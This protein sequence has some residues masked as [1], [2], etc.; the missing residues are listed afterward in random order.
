MNSKRIDF[1]DFIDIG[2][3]NLRKIPNQFRG[4]SITPKFDKIKIPEFFLK[5]GK[6]EEEFKSQKSGN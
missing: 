5:I 4:F 3:I 6:E 2:K 1:R